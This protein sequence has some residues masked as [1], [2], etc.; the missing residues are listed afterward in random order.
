MTTLPSLFVSHGAPDLLLSDSPARSFLA[1]LNGVLPSKPDAIVMVS[2]HWE[3]MHPSVNAPTVHDTIHDF[4]GFDPALFQVRY[5]APGSHALARRIAFM[6]DAFGL[7]VDID[8]T[9]GLDHGAWVPLALAWP[10]ADIPIVQLSVQTHAGV[11]HHFALGE[12]LAPLRKENILIMGSGSI[13]H[14]LRSYSLN[15]HELDAA[16]P[17]WVTRFADW[18]YEAVAIGDWTALRNYRACAPES[19]RNH[20]TE[21]HLLPLFVAI[22]A[23]GANSSTRMLHRSTMHGALRMDAYAFGI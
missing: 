20:P 7:R 14:N 6:G 1:N 18:I 10:Q 11:D 21:E 12:L 16:E 17:E 8:G 23:G 9:R 22:G 3:T 2:A 15:R 13:T 4:G 19:V 5:S